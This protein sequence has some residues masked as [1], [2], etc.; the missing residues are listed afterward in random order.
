M[1]HHY[2]GPNFGFPRDDARLDLTDL[3]A[4][5]KPRD[6]S[7][8]I[9]IFNAHPSSSV[10]PVGPT[11]TEPFSPDARYEL[12]IDTNGDARADITYRATFA[13]DGHGGQTATLRRIEGAKGDGEIIVEHAPVSMGRDALVSE[14]RGHRIFAGWRS[15]PFFFDTLGALDNLR[16]TGTDFFA[17]KDVCSIAL[18]VPNAVLGA[19][20][21]G[22]W[23]RAL[24]RSGDEWIQ[25]ERGARP[26]IAVFL[27]GEARDAY[28]AAQ[29]SDDA[30]FIDVFAHALQHAGGYAPNDATRAAQ[31][32]LPDVMR[33]DPARPASYP[34]NGRALTDNVVD[35][36]LPI[37]TNGKIKTENVG[38]HSDLLDAFPYVGRP[39]RA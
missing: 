17:D 30:R 36:F 7:K 25:V 5:P 33:Y 4:F 12:A 15:D 19:K 13:P 29:P 27:A 14:G 9:L 23:M 6:S 35:F 11:T 34:T 3:F 20:P 37:L 38:P 16:F 2:S 21:V 31:Q 26:Q 1:S 32:L 28:Q 8:S 24:V 22:L 18:E 39:H 10:N